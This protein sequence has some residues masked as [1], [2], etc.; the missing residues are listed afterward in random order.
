MRASVR[1]YDA[2][3]WL[4]VY[5]FFDAYL[6]PNELH[7]LAHFNQLVSG[8]WLGEEEALIVRR[9][10]V[11]C[12]D[13]ARRLHSATGKCI[14]YHDGWGFYAWHGVQVPERVI[15]SPEMLTREDFLSEK[16][17]EV[18]RVIQ[19]RMGH[20]FVSAIGGV[21]LERSPRGTLYEVDLSDD[22]EGV[23]HYVQVQDASAERQ[24]FLRVPP[25]IR[26]AAE[27]VAW[28]FQVGV[29]DYQPTDET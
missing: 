17:V 13:Q 12:R 24:Y 16:N 10:R 18:R 7:A 25:T 27:A 22:P 26:T 2:A 29:E 28:T 20:R 9:P 1:A 4:A 11:L 8:H 21:V 3:P 5:Q 19:E 6:A 14:E 23:A 15:L